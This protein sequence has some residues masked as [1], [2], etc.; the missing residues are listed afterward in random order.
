MI[1]IYHL[2]LEKKLW[3]CLVEEENV[4]KVNV[5]KVNVIKVNAIKVKAIKQN[6]IELKKNCTK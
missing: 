5:I 6:I 3:V 1:A 2:T 4:I